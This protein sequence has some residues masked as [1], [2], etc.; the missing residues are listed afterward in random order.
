VLLVLLVVL[1]VLLV[2]LVLQVLLVL[3]VLLALL[4]LLELPRR[5]RRRRRRVVV[6][7]KLAIMQHLPDCDK[8]TIFRI[9]S[10]H[11]RVQGSLN[12]RQRP[13]DENS[14]SGMSVLIFRGGRHGGHGKTS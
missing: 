12:G 8:S 9:S 3:L 7:V 10:K 11:V 13:S 1:V 14:K 4:F 2:L 6:V 5:H